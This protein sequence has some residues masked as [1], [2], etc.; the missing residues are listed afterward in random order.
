M[1]TIAIAHNGFKDK[2]GIPRQSGL[3]QTETRLVIQKD[4][5]HEEAFRGIEQFSHL[6]LIWHFDAKPS[7]TVRPPRLGGNKRL[8]VF[9][10]RSPFRP[11]QLGLTVVR[12]KRVDYTDGITLIVTGADLMDGTL[13]YDI[14]PYLPYVDSLPDAQG[15]FAADTADYRLMVDFSK[16]IGTDLLNEQTQAEVESLLALDPRPAYQDDAQ[17]IYGMNYHDLE[18]KFR[19]EENTCFVVS[20]EKQV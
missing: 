13:I 14:K 15:G 10:T 17:R 12:L 18:V 19:V 16:A 1:N 11:N 20:I 4:Y 9:A 8:G 6:W 5:A 7:L 2:F 3:A